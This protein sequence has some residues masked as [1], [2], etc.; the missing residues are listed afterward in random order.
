MDF[1]LDLMLLEVAIFGIRLHTYSKAY[2]IMSF[3]A[4]SMI[5]GWGQSI[6][7]HRA[8]DLFSM[9]LESA[10]E[11]QRCEPCLLFF[12]LMD[13]VPW[14]FS[15]RLPGFFGFEAASRFQPEAVK[16]NST[17][18]HSTGNLVSITLTDLF[19]RPIPGTK[20]KGGLSGD[21]QT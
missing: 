4:R 14:L 17:E 12:K 6:I 8:F 7:C 5:G 1:L 18:F 3:Q 13:H 9:L 20:E 11:E 2:Q 16:Y 21:L 10:D 19:F 15:S